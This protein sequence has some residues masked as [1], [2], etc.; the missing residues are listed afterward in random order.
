MPL[1]GAYCRP[2]FRIEHLQESPITR[3]AV[4]PVSWTEGRLN[5]AATRRRSF[6]RARAG[7]RSPCR[8]RR[9]PFVVALDKGP[10][11]VPGLLK[12]LEVVRVQALLLQRANEPFHDAVAIGF[13]HVHRR[14]ADAEPLDL[15]LERLRPVLRAQSCLRPRPAATALAK[16]PMSSRT[17]CRTGSSNPFSR[18]NCRTRFSP[19]RIPFAARRA[20]TFRC[21]SPTNALSDS[22]VWIPTTNSSSLNSVFEPRLSGLSAPPGPGAARTRSNETRPTPRTLA[23]ADTTAPSKDSSARAPQE[24]PQLLPVPPSFQELRLKLHPHRHLPRP[25]SR[26]PRL[27]VRRVPGLQPVTGTPPE[28]SAASAPAPAAAPG[29][30]G[31][32]RQCPRPGAAAATP[33]TPP[34]AP[35]LRQ[36]LGLL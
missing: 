20:R 5:H 21:P 23:S 34:C 12:R 19:A 33:P 9:K 7:V 29:S 36:P 27:P 22:T 16:P 6:A 1:S 26:P 30:P 25:R 14:G 31:S 15:R 11:H 2:P 8:W 28:T 32:P 4:V 18:I 17:P 3:R 35:A 24:L 10:D 13:A